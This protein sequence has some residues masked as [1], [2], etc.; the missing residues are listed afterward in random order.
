MYCNFGVERASEVFIW[1]DQI[2]GLVQ[3]RCNY[4]ANA[5]ELRLSSINLLNYNIVLHVVQQLEL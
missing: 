1:Y 5:L 2:E 3:V 4:I